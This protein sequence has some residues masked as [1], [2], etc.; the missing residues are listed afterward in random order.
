MAWRAATGADLGWVEDLLRAHVQSSMFLLANLR[1]HGLGSDAPRGLNLWVRTGAEQGVFAVTNS[2]MVM[3]QAPGAAPEDWQAAAA[4]LAG[5]SLLGCIGETGQVRAVLCA[6]GLGQYPR[7]VDRDEP[8]FALDLAGLKVLAVPGT[9]LLPLSAMPRG[10]AED[11]R[12]DY[13]VEI[14]GAAPQQAAAVSARE[15]AE[16]L[17][18]DSHR[19]LMA[20]GVPVAMTGFNAALPDVVQIGGVYTPPEQRNRGWA[21][22]AVALHLAEARQRGVR[23]AVLFAASPAAVRA[24]TAIGFRRA[25]S[26]SLVLF[27]PEQ[28]AA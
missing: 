9:E 7:Q 28:E 3:P 8:C 27:A 1:A 22:L 12:R 5:R 6:A 26:Y 15:V 23:K 18:R 11:W 10:L 4:L 2:G 13:N 24:Y 25:G 20:E 19:V 17:E 16:Y 21:R 14:L